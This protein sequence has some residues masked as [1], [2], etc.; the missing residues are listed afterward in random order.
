L[1]VTELSNF[2]PSVTSGCG[3]LS[4]DAFSTESTTIVVAD[5]NA[6]DSHSMTVLVNGDS[7]LPAFMTKSGL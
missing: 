5:S 1:T 4:V 7:T 2:A 6:G 3:N